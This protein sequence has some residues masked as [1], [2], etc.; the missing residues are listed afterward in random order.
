MT[1]TAISATTP[2]YT[3]V[4]NFK[5]TYAPK[6]DAGAAGAAT[7]TAGTTGT[8]ATTSGTGAK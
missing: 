6:G 3:F 1:G 5:F 2:V 8:S 7:G 4:M